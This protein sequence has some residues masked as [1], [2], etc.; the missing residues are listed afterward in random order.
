MIVCKKCNRFVNETTGICPNCKVLLPNYKIIAK[1]IYGDPHEYRMK[2]ISCGKLFSFSQKELEENS[3]KAM[4]T[5]ITYLVGGL[6]YLFGST[7]VGAVM[8]GN[9]DR[10]SADIRDYNR[11][12][13][14]NSADI[15]RLTI[16]EY[17]VE[18]EKN[19]MPTNQ[20]SFSIADEILKFK[21]LLDS[22]IIS[23]SEFEEQKR[24]LLRNKTPALENKKENDIEVKDLPPAEDK[25]IEEVF[26][27]FD[28]YIKNLFNKETK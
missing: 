3:D 9:A 13:Y 21:T 14:C 7:V 18:V 26:S 22:G 25:N 12:P 20:T 1:K 10:K 5:G 24:K 4:R 15:H 23:Q 6:Q 11:C 8:E 19:N 16:E 28:D 2:C 27:S 17:Q